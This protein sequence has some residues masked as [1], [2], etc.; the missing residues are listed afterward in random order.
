MS[1]E[2]ES[3][4]EYIGHTRSGKRYRV[5]YSSSLFED[6]SDNTREQSHTHKERTGG[7]P[8]ITLSHHRN[9]PGLRI[10]PQELHLVVHTQRI[11]PL[12]H[13]HLHRQVVVIQQIRIHLVETEWGMT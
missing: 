5:D 11:L 8:H 12:F 2:S 3:D 6:S 4:S 13:Q 9:H 1:V 7:V 10:I